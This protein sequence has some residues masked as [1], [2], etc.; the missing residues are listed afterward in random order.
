MSRQVRHANVNGP[1]ST[2]H[3]G[4]HDDLTLIDV[5]WIE[6]CRYCRAILALVET[7]EDVGQ[8]IKSGDV[9]RRLGVLAGVQVWIVLYLVG[10]DGEIESFRVRR[11]YPDPSPFF[12][13]VTPD[14]WRYFLESLRE[15]HPDGRP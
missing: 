2:W 1:Y 14:D 4:L 3:R 13:A 11:A 10:V 9:L 5:D 6:Y 8:S 7:A 12:H 15:C